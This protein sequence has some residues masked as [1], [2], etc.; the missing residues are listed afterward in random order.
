MD[1]GLDGRR[2]IVIGGTRGIG[3]AIVERLIAEGCAVALCA[4][5]PDAVASF[6]A[7]LSAGGAGVFGAAV[8][9]GD[10]DALRAF[11]DE[12]ATHL[13]GLDVFV[14]NASGAFGGGNDED[15][16]R[17]GVEVD[18][19]GTVAGCEAAIPHLSASGSG[20][21][22]AVGTVSAIEAVG[23]RRA[24]NSVKAAVIPYIKSIARELA[25][26]VRANVVSPGQ[27]FFDGGVWDYVRQN[28]PERYDEAIAS[29]PMGRMG[30]PREVAD[31]V[32]FLASPRASFISGTN[33]LCDGARTQN[34][35]Y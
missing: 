26:A 19:L 2:A 25:P 18:I 12:A 22:V 27:V 34:V 4:R 3:R 15:S 7:E 11:V 33:L 16:W 31:A 10:H 24:Y 35:Q 6:V 1:L 8:D 23:G 28:V 21:I 5:N 14:M 9:A 30:E 32:A 20:A 17:R 29:D 13:G